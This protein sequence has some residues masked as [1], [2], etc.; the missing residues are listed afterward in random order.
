MCEVLGLGDYSKLDVA[1]TAHTKTL[2]S[3]WL[4]LH[5]PAQS[6]EGSTE[7]PLNFMW[8]EI[9]N[10]QIKNL[11]VKSQEKRTTPD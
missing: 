2:S 4:E 11:R 6:Q 3:T 8:M 7:D 10:R 9:V 5:E 1:E